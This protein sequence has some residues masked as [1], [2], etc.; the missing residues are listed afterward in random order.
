MRLT[1]VSVEDF[2]KEAKGYKAGK[3]QELIREFVESGKT[4]MEVVVGEGEYKQKASA[5]NVLNVAAKKMNHYSTVK[6]I[7]RNGKI[8]LFNPQEIDV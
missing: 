2:K 7:T 1:E 5:T 8:Y 6:A 4:V 3:A